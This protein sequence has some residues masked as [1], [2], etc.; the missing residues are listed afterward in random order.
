MVDDGGKQVRIHRAVD[1][2]DAVDDLA[3]PLVLFLQPGN[4]RL[5]ICKTIAVTP[6][7]F[8]RISEM[9]DSTSRM[10]VIF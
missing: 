10:D 9:P 3:E 1:V 8:F 4:L 6:Y 5:S 7:R 2:P